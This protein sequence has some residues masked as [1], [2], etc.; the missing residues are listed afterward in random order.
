MIEHRSIEPLLRS[1][2]QLRGD[3]LQS[4]LSTAPADVAAAESAITDLYRLVGRGRPEF[5]WAP[6]PGAAVDVVADLGLVGAD[7]LKSS[8][9]ARVP[10]L[11]AELIT[12]SHK[13]MK[14]RIRRRASYDPFPKQTPYHPFDPYFLPADSVPAESDVF[15]VLRSAVWDSMRTTLLD[16]VVAPIR[17]MRPPPTGVITWYGQHEAYRIAYFDIVRRLG[18]VR[19]ADADDSLL[20]LQIALARVCGWWWAFDDVCVVSHRP[21]AL[22]LEPAPGASSGER[23]LHHRDDPAI[24]FADDTT[25]FALHGTVVPE[26]VIREPTIDRIASE[27]NIEVRRSAI[28]RLGWETFIARAE[29]ELLDRVPDPGNPGA[30]LELY[31]TPD[32]WCP[33]SRILLAVNGSVERDGTRRRYGLNVPA[34]AESA[35]DAAGWTYGLPG[36][37][38]A[39]LARRT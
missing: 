37:A 16:G 38:Y 7:P 12:G 35:L 28:E 5:V 31:A 3:W 10:A 14:A 20:D 23:R 11:V 29:L 17:R 39:Q 27:P 24:R 19:Y 8:E 4:A 21:V 9:R 1:S 15:T 25:L 26:W 34:W 13:G 32:D 18:L 30:L 22:H 6:S 33:R 2:E 36:P